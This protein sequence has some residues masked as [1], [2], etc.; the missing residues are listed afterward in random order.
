M[1]VEACQIPLRPEPP[2]LRP[3]DL[4]GEIGG[5]PEAI[6]T[7]KRV[8]DLP[9]EQRLRREEVA[10]AVGCEVAQLA[11][12]RRVERPGTHVGGAERG[13]PSAQLTCRLV[14]ERHG[15]QARR[16]KRSRSD[17]MREAPRDRRRLPRAGTR[18]DADRAAHRLRGAALL[19]VQ[20]VEDVHRG[21][22]ARAA[23]DECAV[24]A[25]CL[26]G[27]LRRPCAPARGRSTGAGRPRRPCR[28][29][30]RAARARRARPPASRGRS[31][32]APHA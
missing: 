11:E 20:P 21:T 18:K 6:R 16:R 2:V 26:R 10:D 14:G 19:G 32:R 23:A 5:G 12:R 22:V 31:A 30:R 4:G 1:P 27:R 25:S 13:Q 15:H 9:E 3:L 29:R 7:R 8:A 17:L 28:L 24:S